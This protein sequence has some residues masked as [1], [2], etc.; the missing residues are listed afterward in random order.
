[1]VAAVRGKKPIL[2]LGHSVRLHRIG[3][4]SKDAFLFEI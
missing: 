1:M 4:D 2:L 3:W